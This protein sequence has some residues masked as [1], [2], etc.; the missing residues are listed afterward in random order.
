MTDMLS[1]LSGDDSDESIVADET[2][3][4]EAPVAAAPEP[5]ADAPQRGPDGRF[6]PA[7]PPAQADAAPAVA[8]APAGQASPVADH[9][10]PAPA[11]E[12]VAASE[13][14][15]PP[16]SALLDERERRQRAE[17]EARELRARIEALERQPAPKAPDR[18]EDPEGYEQHQQDRLDARFQQ[19]TF[20]TSRRFAERSYGKE[21]ADSLGTWASERCKADPQ[22]AQASLQSSDPYEFAKSHRDRETILAEVKPD[23]LAA[24]KAWQASRASGDPAPIPQTQPVAA[25]PAAAH[26]VPVVTAPPRSLAA[27]PSAAGVEHVPSGPG[28]AFDGLFQ[29]G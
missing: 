28:Q 13:L 11:A 2:P 8:A 24:F 23:D 14:P 18:Y 20:E 25:A 16:L 26:A 4:A 17:G 6:A 21:E 10:A 12:P 3:V 27:V 7:A 19:F 15:T 9:P 5:A 22:F 1:F 29:K